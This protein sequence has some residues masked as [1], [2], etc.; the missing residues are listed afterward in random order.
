MKRSIL[1]P[2]MTILHLF[3]SIKLPIIGIIYNKEVGNFIELA[4]FKFELEKPTIK[5][6]TTSSSSNHA[7]DSM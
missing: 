4:K 1:P 5:K 7:A 2:W 3:P 6:P